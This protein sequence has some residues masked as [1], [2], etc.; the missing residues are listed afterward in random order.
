M[1]ET[2]FIP[3]ASDPLVVERL[4]EWL[5]EKK[6]W[7][8]TGHK[9]TRSNAKPKEV[10]VRFHKDTEVWWFEHYRY[11]TEPGTDAGAKGPAYSLFRDALPDAL[12]LF[13]SR[14][15]ARGQTTRADPARC[16]PLP[17]RRVHE[18][19]PACRACGPNQPR[20]KSINLG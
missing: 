14:K 17:E 6:P 8:Y 2:E 15:E 12:R 7:A 18:R 1:A 16:V 20:P 11:V 5:L 13:R 10:W 9:S 19:R 3:P 4:A